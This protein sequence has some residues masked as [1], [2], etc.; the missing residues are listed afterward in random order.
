MNGLLKNS[1]GRMTPGRAIRIFCLGCT[2]G[3]YGEVESCDGDGTDP[4]YHACP[5]HPYRMGRGR[6]SVRITRKFCLQC[7]GETPSL[8]RECETID[9]PCHLY[10]MGKNP[11]RIGKGHFADQARQK[12]AETYPVNGAFRVQNARTAV[13]MA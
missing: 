10:R 4:A 7:M 8:V 11:A 5:F 6:P 2:G 9:C 13:G 1:A 12:K 3:V